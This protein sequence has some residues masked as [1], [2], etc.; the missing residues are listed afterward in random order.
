M[1]TSPRPTLKSSVT[2]FS[3]RSTL[4]TAGCRNRPPTPPGLVRGQAGKLSSRFA[5]LPRWNLSIPGG[6]SR[7]SYLEAFLSNQAE[8]ASIAV[9]PTPENPAHL[10]ARA[11]C[12]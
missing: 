11:D 5:L 6:S 1:P 4:H 3:A 2:I 9:A 12:C 8:A 7:A 10:S